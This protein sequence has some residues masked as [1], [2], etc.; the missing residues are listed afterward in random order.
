MADSFAGYT[1]LGWRLCYFR[2]WTILSQAL[3]DFKVLIVILL[4]FP[5]YVT[6]VLRLSLFLFF[7]LQFSMLFISC[8]FLT[9]YLQYTMGSFF[10]GHDYLA[11]YVLLCISMVMPFLNLGEFSSMILK[12]FYNFDHCLISLIYYYTWKV[13]YLLMVS[14]ISWIFLPC[15]F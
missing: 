2:T 9:F 8:V 15:V 11:F 3:W 13:W 6:C 7:L 5:L 14:Y 12:K 1:S 4:S 10:S